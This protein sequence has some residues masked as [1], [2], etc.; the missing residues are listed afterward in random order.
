MDRLLPTSRTR[1]PL[2]R[3]VLALVFTFV[4]ARQEASAQPGSMIF[5]DEFNR[6]VLGAG[7]L[8]GDYWASANG[9]AY[10]VYDWGILAT[11]K[12]YNQESYVIETAAKGFTA[13]YW[14]EFRILF[15]Q[16]APDDQKTYVITYGP[17]SG[18]QLT[19]GRSTD[20]IYYPQVL[21]AVSIYPRLEKDKLY[22]FKIARYKSGLIQVYLDKGTGY[23]QVPLLEAIDTAYQ[24]LGHFG[25]QVTTQT[26]PEIFY[27]DRIQATVP[28]LEKPAVRQKPAGDSLITQVSASSGKL[29]NVAK[30]SEGAQIYSD[31][32]FKATSVPSYLMGASF[33]QT[34]MDDKKEEGSFELVTFMKK[35][36]VLYVAYDS[37]ATALPEW[38]K[39]WHKTGDVIGT[40]DPK[41]KNLQVYSKRADY[42]QVY[43]RPFILG[44]NMASPAAGAQANYMVIAV[45]V[46]DGN[47]LEAENALLSGAKMANNHAGYS[48]SGFVD[49]INASKDY[50]EWTAHVKV[51]GSYTIGFQFS[52]GSTG[53]RP[54]AVSVDNVGIGAFSFIPLTSWEHWASYSGP[55]VFLKEGVHKIRL[56]AN[57]Q[58]GPNIDFLSLSFFDAAPNSIA[59]GALAR[60]GAEGLDYI[61]DAFTPKPA[62]YPNPFDNNTIISYQLAQKNKVTLT[63]YSAAGKKHT[64]L[65]D[66]V[67]DP[68]KYETEFNSNNLPGGLYLYHLQQGDDVTVGKILKK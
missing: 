63:I 62:A 60:T 58:S 4:F 5:K 18:G 47:K 3:I 14:R 44:G 27:V 55:R 46:P 35:P 12:N 36:V 52:N 7:W 19:L 45:Q 26:A 24:N 43:P 37:R 10:N 56:T 42:W 15:G 21:D 57:G 33:V 59:G 23:G 61:S 51:P 53:A 29:Y 65:V 41:M 6:N 66:K 28:E 34:A 2:Y 1:F 17:D 20:N 13:S 22:K 39:S 49:F 9:F 30:L 38:L 40:N 67:M 48:G 16:S 68:G 50:I 11:S 31:R 32:A 8:P 54:L 64:V 25:W